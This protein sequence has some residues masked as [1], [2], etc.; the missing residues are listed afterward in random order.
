MRLVKFAACVVSAIALV[1]F[2]GYS[3]EESNAPGFGS[4]IDTWMEGTLKSID[5]DGKKFV[6]HGGQRPYATQY[7][8]MM[9]DI[10][11]KTANL[12]G[13]SATKKADEIRAAWADKLNKAANESPQKE[14][15]FTFHVATKDGSILCRD[16]SLPKLTI[17]EPTHKPMCTS[18]KDFNIEQFVIVGYEAGVL[19]NDAFVVIKANRPAETIPAGF[20]T[21]E[22]KPSAVILDPET[23][24]TL[25]IRR[26]IMDDKTLSTAA[27]NVV[28]DMQKGVAHLK[29]AVDS[30]AEKTSV[31]N[32][33][34]SV[35]GG[36]N[37]KNELEV[38]TTK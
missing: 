37:V 31:V 30:D 5:A 9:K 25:Q 28:I 24:Q 4:K 14:S 35:M 2:S 26:M 32:K 29:G 36:A 12:D 38:K 17:P 22:P 20:K 19:R 11:D 18:M 15:D 21:T 6:V 3:A 8:K 16:E 13:D 10:G 27:H 1:S 7:A 34:I 23:E 33:A